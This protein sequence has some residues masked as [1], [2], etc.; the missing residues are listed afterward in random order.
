MLTDAQKKFI[1]LEKKKEE[2]KAYF[3][4]LNQAVEEVAKEIGVGGYFQ[5]QEGTVYKIVVPE[6]KFVYFEKL[7][8]ERTRRAGE[9]SGSLSLKEAREKGYT[10]E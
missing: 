7:S 1:E 6:G 10:V 4:Q 8:Y 5:D 3:D 2:V 9:K